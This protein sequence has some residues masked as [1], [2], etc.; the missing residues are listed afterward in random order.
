MRHTA[1]LT[2][3]G[4]TFDVWDLQTSP[5]LPLGYMKAHTT[6][7][8]FTGASYPDPVGPYEGNLAAFLDGG[9]RLFMSGQDILD[10][11]A[12]TA[13][14]FQNYVH[15]A[16]DDAN[17]NDKATTS[18][19]GVTGNPVSDGIGNVPL[20]PSVLG[21]DFQYMDRITPITPAT[22]AFTDDSAAA[23]ALTVAFGAYKI[24]FLGFPFEEY[25]SAPQK[26]DL[27]NRVLTYFG[28]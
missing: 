3:N 24:V 18:V 1:A 11:A 19:N 21:L 28:P 22:A 10:Q 26:A 4:K 16:W 6:I 12:G 8:W 14:F 23:D 9:G 17:Q 20:D 2:A 27:M 15:I 5:V 25:G 7:V 13:P